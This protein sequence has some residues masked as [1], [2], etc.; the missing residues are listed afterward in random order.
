[1]SMSAQMTRSQQLEA[2]HCKVAFAAV[3]NAIPAALKAVPKLLPGMARMAGRAGTALEQKGLWGA[4]KGL[5]GKAEN[6]AVH[7]PMH[8]PPVTTAA[9]TAHW[10]TGAFPEATSASKFVNTPMSTGPKTG[11]GWWGAPSASQLARGPRPAGFFNPKAWNPLRH[12]D[13]PSLLRRAGRFAGGTVRAGRFAGGTVRN[14]LMFAGLGA[15]P[16]AMMLPGQLRGAGEQGAAR[17]LMGMREGGLW[18]RTK[19]MAGMAWGSDEDIINEI[20]KTEPGVAQN[21]RALSRNQPSTWAQI[22]AGLTGQPLQ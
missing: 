8:V 4:T 7:T 1:M 13:D 14:G 5:F 15:I 17:A 16:Q 10:G 22:R 12:A 11:N 20:A 18:D 9:P 19:R 2:A 21:M 6:A 3:G